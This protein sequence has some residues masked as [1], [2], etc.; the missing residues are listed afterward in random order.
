MAIPGVV[1]DAEA[2]VMALL[3]TQA[4]AILSDEDKRAAVL[5]AIRQ[6]KLNAARNRGGVSRADQLTHALGESDANE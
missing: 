2:N 3:W 6:N 4:A 1:T 5:E